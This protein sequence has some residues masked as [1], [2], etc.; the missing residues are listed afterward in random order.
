MVRSEQNAGERLGL[1]AGPT[2][3]GTYV[4]R[5]AARCGMCG[6]QYFVNESVSAAIH[7]AAE[8]GLDNPFMCPDCE[9]EYD[10]LAYE[11]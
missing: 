6:G 3:Y 10:E 4:N 2:S 7:T 9:E 1:D 11:G 5:F 8:V